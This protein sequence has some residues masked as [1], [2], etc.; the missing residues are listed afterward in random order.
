LQLAKQRYTQKPDL[1]D[2]RLDLFIAHANMIL[3]AGVTN[4]T[5]AMEAHAREAL[6][7]MPAEANVEPAEQELVSGIQELIAQVLGPVNAARSGGF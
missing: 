6:R 1:G 4:D 3:A 7:L 2:A 5:P